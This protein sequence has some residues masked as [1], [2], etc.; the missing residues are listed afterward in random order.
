MHF[1]VANCNESCLYTFICYEQHQ[2][3]SDCG[4]SILICGFVATI[5]NP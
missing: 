1:F 5:Y 4:L 2:L 3:R